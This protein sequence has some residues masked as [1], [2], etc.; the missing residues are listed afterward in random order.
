MLVT[1]SKLSSKFGTRSLY[2]LRKIQ[3]GSLFH[4]ISSTSTEQNNHVD[5]GNVVKNIPTSRVN[6]ENVEI[7]G[8]LYPKDKYT[9]VTDTILSKVGRNLHLLN[10][11]PINIIKRKIENLIPNF[12][13]YED[14]DPV[15][16]KTDNF[17]KLL[18]PKDHPSRALTDTY[19]VNEND[20]LRTHTSAH[21]SALIEKNEVDSF[22]VTADVY[23][24]DE[25]NVT[26]YPIF[27][28]MEGVLLFDRKNVLND[29][30]IKDS[31][32]K[33]QKSKNKFNPEIDFNKENAP[34]SCHTPEEVLAISCHLRYTL[35]ELIRGLFKETGIK[36]DLVIRWLPSY[37]PFTS[38]SFEMEILFNGEWLEVLGCGMMEQDIIDNAGHPDKIGWAFGLGL[39]RIAMTVFDI[40]DI[41]LF[42]SKDT[43][44]LNQFK[45][46][47]FT[48]FQPFS[49]YPA[50][51][52]DL[53]FW[54]PIK[55]GVNQEIHDN[56]F[57]ELVRNVAED[58]VEDVRL[59]DEFTNK[60]GKKS[61]CYRI[62]YRCM[63][64]TMTTEEAMDLHNE[65]INHFKSKY[66]GVIIR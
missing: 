44:F 27:H 40:P 34:Q 65:I 66:E 11:H 43:R 51:Y 8:K 55:D 59:I 4:G 10:D 32:E 13:N 15:V 6:T 33:I 48:K 20:L 19:H 1:A 45:F 25:I 21:Q 7:L 46:N 23:R 36:D 9:N 18:I 17:D 29:I 41:R 64:R 5:T 42:W 2:D 24:R 54:L 57:I 53:S 22:L 26:H 52:K 3:F 35:E 58:V 56:D 50:C 62:N 38:P 37:F 60:K 63:D 47:Q 31:I 61:K 12:K 30:R 14:L 49:K 16:T 39:E 28:Q